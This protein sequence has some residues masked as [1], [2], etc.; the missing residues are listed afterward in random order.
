MK[1]FFINVLLV[2][3]F[4]FF[5]VNSFAICVRIITTN[6][7]PASNYYTEPGKGTANNWSGAIDTSGT[8]GTT[9]RMIN[10]TN[11][12]FQPLG[13]LI[14][15]GYISF[16]ESGSSRYDPEQILFRCSADEESSLREFYAT[17]GDSSYAGRYLVNSALGLNDTYTTIVRDVGIRVKNLSTGEYF[18]RYWKSRPLKNLD[19]DSRGWLLVKAKNFSDA[20]IELFK[21]NYTP[22]TP[23]PMSNT[24]VVVWSQPS[25]YIAFKSKMFS[26]NLRDGADSLNHYGGFHAHWPG[27]I[28]LHRNIVVNRTATCILENLTPHVSFPRIS[29]YDLNNN[30]KVTAPINI[31]FKCQS[32]EGRTPGFFGRMEN[33][34]TAIGFLPKVE[35]IAAAK[36]ENLIVS[37]GIGVTHLLSDGYGSM[38]N[39]A[40]GVGIRLYQTNGHPLNFI[41]SLSSI[42]Q[43]SA[44][45]WYSILT[46]A[47]LIGQANGTEGYSTTINASLEKLPGKT[48]T[49]GKFDASLQ[50]IIQVQ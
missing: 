31:R 3:S 46:N 38:P 30:M 21:I 14:A 43:G 36:R 35:N 29:K 26:L 8:M 16:L 20:S 39:I 23:V 40:T 22:R 5:S 32:G 10:V 19:K 28:S 6:T 44:N 4:S 45:G 15:T 33:L 48:A 50:V 42:G 2:L 47:L 12:D 37:S 9:P 34:K 17:N 41:S 7:Y 1:Y 49:A 18:S 13:S 25:A 11:D 27:A 24:G